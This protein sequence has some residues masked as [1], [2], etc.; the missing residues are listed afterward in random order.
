MSDYI[1]DR[2]HSWARWALRGSGPT[3]FPHETILYRVMRDGIIVRGTG[4]R[5]EP[6]DH[7]E[8]STDKAVLALKD[9][10]PEEYAVIC[11]HYLGK[12]TVQQKWKDLGLTKMRYFNALNNGKAWIESWLMATESVV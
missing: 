8:Y 3:G 10:R 7:E 11:H 4:H 5:P 9:R 1:D 12:G 2:L 6:E